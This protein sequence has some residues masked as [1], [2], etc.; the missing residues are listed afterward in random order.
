MHTHV[1]IYSG[2]GEPDLQM[3]FV[4]AF[5][6]D[7]D[8]VQTYV[9]VRGTHCCGGESICRHSAVHEELQAHS[10]IR[11]IV[12]TPL[13]VRAVAGTLLYKSNRMHTAV[14]EELQAYDCIRAIAGTLLY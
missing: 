5:P 8:G 7:P 2:E 3:R 6:L 12:G 11:A 14:H 9:K 13:R 10:C 4:P 1:F